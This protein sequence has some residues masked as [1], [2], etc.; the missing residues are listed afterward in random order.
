MNVQQQIRKLDIHLSSYHQAAARSK[1]YQCAFQFP[2][3]IL[4]RYSLALR[5]KHTNKF[6]DD[7]PLQSLSHAHEQ[8]IG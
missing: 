5:Y 1:H 2:S 6:H 8:L 7:Q 3:Q 4:K